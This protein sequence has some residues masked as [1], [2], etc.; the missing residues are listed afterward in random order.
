MVLTDRAFV[1]AGKG[2]LDKMRSPKIICLTALEIDD[3]SAQKGEK[4]LHVCLRTG[5]KK[6][7]FMAS[8]ESTRSDWSRD[9][10]ECIDFVQLCI[11]SS[12]DVN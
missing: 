12:T 6:L 7:I 9:L 2:T 1:Y 5:A 10:S 3:E 4:N 8:D 11:S